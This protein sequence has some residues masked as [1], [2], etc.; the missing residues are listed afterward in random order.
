MEF[1]KKIKELRKT[2]N[3]TQE[4]LAGYLNISPQAVSRW[5]CGVSQT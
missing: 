2:Q 5:E 1:H 4:Q 3:I